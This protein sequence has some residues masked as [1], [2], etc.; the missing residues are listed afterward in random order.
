[1]YDSEFPEPNP[2][3][4][5]EVVVEGVHTQRSVVGRYRKKVALRGVVY[6]WFTGDAFQVLVEPDDVVDMKD[7]GRFY[8]RTI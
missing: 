4:Y 1:M 7:V 3:H 2:G 6:W 5:Y 8:G